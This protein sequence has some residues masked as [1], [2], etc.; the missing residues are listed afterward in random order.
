MCV[1]C[2]RESYSEHKAKASEHTPVSAV[3]DILPSS[4]LGSDYPKPNSTISLLKMVKDNLYLHQPVWDTFSGA[5]HLDTNMPVT[6]RIRN[7]VGSI[8]DISIC[9]V[10]PPFILNMAQ[11]SS[12]QGHYP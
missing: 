6:C 8:H 2:V 11:W 9:N 12:G 10:S 1:L 5:K 3:R 4:D 7:H